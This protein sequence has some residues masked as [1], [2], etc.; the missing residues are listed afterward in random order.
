MA[1]HPQMD[2]QTKRVN[3]EVEQF[4]QLFVNQRKDD[5]YKWLAIAEFTYNN[6]IHTS[7]HSSP[8]MMD[9][10]QNPQLSIEPL[11]ESCLE[12]LNDFASQMKWPQKKHARPYLRWQT[13]WPTSTIPTG[14]RPHCIQLETR[15]GSMGRISL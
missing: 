7:T 10:G 11:R 15:S 8:F 9:M 3:Q 1:Y 5:W 13:T 4:L 12:T 14:E 2:S 6:Q